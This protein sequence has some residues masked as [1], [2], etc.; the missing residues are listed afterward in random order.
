VDIV[1]YV[2]NLGKVMNKEILEQLKKS[3]K[4]LVDLVIKELNRIGIKNNSEL[5]E[6]ISLEYRSVA[7]AVISVV[8]SAD[9]LEYID[10]GR[11]PGSMPPISAIQDFVDVNGIDK[12]AVWPIAKSIMMY[13][14]EARPVL[15][16]IESKLTQRT[17]IIIDKSFDEFIKKQMDIFNIK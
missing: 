6:S 4:A 3:D 12:E 14:I 16:N 10:S 2:N 1:R 5:I 15:D 7:D 13:G 11:N 17:E 8:N 9:Y